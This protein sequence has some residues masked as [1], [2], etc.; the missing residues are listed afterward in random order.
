MSLTTHDNPL[1]LRES[2]KKTFCLGEVWI[3][4]NR[5]KIRQLPSPLPIPILF[6][7]I[8]SMGMRSDL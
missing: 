2:A 8:L 1:S 4:I 7:G 5:G 6:P 3:R